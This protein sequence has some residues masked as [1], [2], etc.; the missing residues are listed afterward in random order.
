MKVLFVSRFVDPFDPRANR[1]IIRQANVLREIG[2]FDLEILTWPHNDYWSGPVPEI[3]NEPLKV[4]RGGC[5]YQVIVGRP[6]WNETAGGNVISETAWTEAVRYGEKILKIISPDVVH[7]HHRFGFWWILESAQRLGIA[8]VYSN[9]D[10]GIACLRTVLVNGRNELCDGRVEPQKCETCVVSG[11]STIMGKANEFLVGQRICE[12]LLTNL[13][14]YPGFA[15]WFR[16]RGGVCIP[17]LKRTKLN[18]QRVSKIMGRLDHCITPSEFGKEFFNQFGI[19][20]DKISV[21][22]WYHDLVRNNHIKSKENSTPFTITYI[23][24]VSPEKGVHLIF[25]AIQH[26]ADIKPIHIRISG[27]N[28]S[29]YCNQLRRRYEHSVGNHRIEWLDWS[30]IDDLLRSTDTTIIPSI[31]MDNTPM[32][33]IEALAYRIPVITTAI[34]T[35]TMLLKERGV[36]YCAENNTSESLAQAIRAAVADQELIRSGEVQFPLPL[37]TKEYC[38][39]ISNIYTLVA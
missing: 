3:A 10:W 6:E 15:R 1:N 21:L 19:S 25:D 5:A 22:P 39:E 28:D 11:R 18:F 8:T 12:I 26:L 35:I 7:L 2:K 32:A 14:Q 31:V 4:S 9:Y 34:P 20:S 29:K 38:E 30:P 13:D 33:L 16:G 36:G 17:A 37:T 24:R 27:A 23:G